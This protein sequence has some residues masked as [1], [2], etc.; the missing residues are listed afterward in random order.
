MN[1]GV[2]SICSCFNSGSGHCGKP[3]LPSNGPWL[4]G[5]HSHRANDPY[6]TF[7]KFTDFGFCS[8][9]QIFTTVDENPYSINDAALAVIA[10]EPEA[11]DFPADFHNNGC[12]FAFADGHSEMHHWLSQFYHL[13]E[14]AS[15][16]STTQAQT[17]QYADWYWVA[18]HATRSY[19]TLTVP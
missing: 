17:S 14:G 7:G 15:E 10:A 4:N 12:G 9:S 11:V 6:A 16:R 1:Q 2:G 5:Q 8:P 19:K 18:S 13:T 3:D